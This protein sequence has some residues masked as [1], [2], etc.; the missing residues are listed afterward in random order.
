MLNRDRS[1]AGEI[2]SGISPAIDGGIVVGGESEDIQITNEIADGGSV[3]SGTADVFAIYNFLSVGGVVLSGETASGEF[4]LA[5]GGAVLGGISD[6]ADFINVLGGVLIG[7]ESVVTTDVFN[8]A[9][10]HRYFHEIGDIVYLRTTTYDERNVPLPRYHQFVVQGIK[11][12]GSDVY[13]DLG[14]GFVHNSFVY[15]Q[16]SQVDYAYLFE[17]IGYRLNVI[18][19]II[20]NVSPSGGTIKVTDAENEESS[21]SSAI[22]KKLYRITGLTPIPS[23]IGGIVTITET[24]NGE[25]LSF[26]HIQDKIEKLDNET[27]ISDPVGG[28]IKDSQSNEI[29]NSGATIENRLS[30][31]DNI[32]VSPDPLGGTV[33]FTYEN[34]VNNSE[35]SKIEKSLQRLNQQSILSNPTGDEI[36]EVQK[37]EDDLDEIRAE[38]QRKIDLLSSIDV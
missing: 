32:D 25:N 17:W 22:N 8:R 19:G 3:V 10:E 12:L 5:E 30:Q 20:P 37:G 9:R 14:F 24:E 29:N 27:V 38:L 13:Y 23:P 31:L 26:K 7:G 2:V 18:S 34:Q 21:D 16:F 35:K 33:K 4:Q 15:D 1:V 6:V 36:L 11:F 28:E